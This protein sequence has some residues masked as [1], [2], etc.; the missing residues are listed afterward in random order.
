MNRPIRTEF[1]GNYKYHCCIFNRY[2]C[3]SKYLQSS[4]V[5]IHS[6]RID[7]VFGYKKTWSSTSLDGQ[8]AI[9][10]WQWGVSNYCKP[11]PSNWYLHTTMAITIFPPQVRPV[12]PGSQSSNESGI[13]KKTKQKKLRKSNNIIFLQ[14]SMNWPTQGEQTPLQDNN[15]QCMWQLWYS[16]KVVLV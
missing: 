2:I 12:R 1:R 6:K 9:A 11:M 7:S 13:E 3:F 15:E 14:M 16:F 8:M 10:T 4:L 5:V